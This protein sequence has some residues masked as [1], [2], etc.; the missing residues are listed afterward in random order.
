MLLGWVVLLALVPDFIHFMHLYL[1][2]FQVEIGAVIL[3]YFQYPA[4][5]NYSGGGCMAKLTMDH[6]SVCVGTGCSGLELFFLFAAFIL[7]IRGNRKSKPL[8]VITGLFIIL[9]F[10]IIRIIALAIINNSHPEYLQFNHK[11]TFVILMYGVIFLLW[12][13]WVNRLNKKDET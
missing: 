1:I 13:F 8:F 6:G 9:V 10:N 2:K 11:Y 5:I 3:N 7:L 4:H 12:M